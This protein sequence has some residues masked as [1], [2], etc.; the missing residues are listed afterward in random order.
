MMYG[1]LGAKS[2]FTQTI[3]LQRLFLGL[4]NPTFQLLNLKKTYSFSNIMKL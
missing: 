2:L 1:L 3:S 4:I